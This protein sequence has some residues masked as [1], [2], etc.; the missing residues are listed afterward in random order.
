MSFDEYIFEGRIKEFED[1]FINYL[2]E[3][4]KSSYSPNIQL[5]L[6]YL[7]I[8]KRLTQ[9]QLKKLTG[10]SGGT[11]SKNLKRIM[12]F[13]GIVKKVRKT[14]SNENYYEMATVSQLA[15]RITEVYSSE[16]SELITF[17]KKK[18]EDL[19]EYE[20]KRGKDLLSE[21]IAEL[22]KTFQTLNN[23]STEITKM[24]TSNN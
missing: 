22:I 6:G 13:G 10:L 7:S 23:I 19:S 24:L 11:I 9:N 4:F 1:I 8:H 15:D 17:L 21:R 5:I 14:G 16:F 12:Q 2:K 18:L 3:R 20:N